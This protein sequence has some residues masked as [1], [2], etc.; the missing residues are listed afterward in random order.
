MNTLKRGMA[1]VFPQGAIHF[2]QNLKC[3]PALFVAGFNNEDPGVLTIAN[4]FIG[5]LP[6]DIVGASLGNLN[7]TKVDDLK[8]FLPHNPALGIAE[9]RKR[10]GLPDTIHN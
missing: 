1:T 3:E 2:E 10:C 5:A 8:N 6:A 4:S 7:I 9:C